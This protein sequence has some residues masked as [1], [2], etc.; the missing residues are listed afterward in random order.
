MSLKGLYAQ[1]EHARLRGVGA[2]IYG[3]ERASRAPRSM[4]LISS[5]Y[6]HTQRS[7]AAPR[8]FAWMFVSECVEL[9]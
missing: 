3:E 1:V 2:S 6:P 4:N 5:D 9:G 8:I 7:R